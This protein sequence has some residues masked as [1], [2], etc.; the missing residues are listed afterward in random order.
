M[1]SAPLTVEMFAGL[2]MYN[3]E[4]LKVALHGSCYSCCRVVVCDKKMKWVD[5]GQT[6]LCPHCGIDSV[7][8]GIVDRKLLEAGREYWFSV[9]GAAKKTTMMV[10]KN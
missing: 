5:D 7:I 10:D 2:S 6:L 9:E 8:P 3:R 1:K 4:D